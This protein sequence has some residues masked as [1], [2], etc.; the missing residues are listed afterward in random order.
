MVQL[1]TLLAQ[2]AILSFA[3]AIPTGHVSPSK[4]HHKGQGASCSGVAM[5]AANASAVSVKNARAVY[6][7]TNA[8]SN[9]IV[10]LKVAAD[11]TL[12][13]GTITCTGGAGMQGIEN[14]APAA[15]DALFSQGALKVAGNVGP[16]S[17]FLHFFWC[18][19][20]Y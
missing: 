20:I 19:L 1:S 10:A 13:D 16:A 17:D 2:I 3:S 14:G 9:S 8:A 6:F 15:P 7:I 11:G 12:S 18:L 4:Y 5:S